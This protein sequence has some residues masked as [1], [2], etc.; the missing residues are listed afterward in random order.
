[1]DRHFKDEAKA[2]LEQDTFLRSFMIALTARVNIVKHNA[3]EAT[4]DMMRRS[5]M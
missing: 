1:M 5:A 4:L 2:W 3:E